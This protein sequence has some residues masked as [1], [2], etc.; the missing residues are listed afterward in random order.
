MII[1]IN[2]E[3]VHG[4]IQCLFMIKKTLNIGLDETYLI[5]KAIYN[6]PNS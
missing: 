6:L 4:K 2:A 1:S 3:K 5:T